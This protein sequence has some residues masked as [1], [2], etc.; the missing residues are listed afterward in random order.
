MNILASFF[1]P[2]IIS[3][4][5]FEF[6]M[7]YSIFASEKTKMQLFILCKRLHDFIKDDSDKIT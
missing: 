3:C 4:I 6:M 1:C 5:Q 2:A 7:T